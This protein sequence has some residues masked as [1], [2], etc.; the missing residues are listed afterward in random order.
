MKSIPFRF[1]VFLIHLLFSIAVIF[2]SGYVVFYIWHPEPLAKAVGVTNIFIMA[3]A[4]F[5][6]LGPLLTFLVTKKGK[7][8]LKFDLI[9]IILL[10]FIAFIFAMYN[11]TISRPVYIVFNSDQ[12]DLIQANSVDRDKLI[13]AH[14]SYQHLNW[15]RPK[16]VAVIPAKNNQEKSDR[17]FIGLQTGVTPSMQPNLYQPVE[18]QWNYLNEVAHSLDELNNFNEQDLVNSILNKYPNVDKW[19]PLRTYDLDMV[20]LIDNNGHKLK[21]VDLRPW[22]LE[23]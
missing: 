7:K 15:G 9:I 8:T 5:I 3:S 11:I 12:F 14:K 22:N 18:D 17:L 10:Q 6:I 16:Y 4:I 13:D 20:V 21:I 23:N 2:I 19:L 1:K